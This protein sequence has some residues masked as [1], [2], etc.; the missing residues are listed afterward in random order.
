MWS[1]QSYWRNPLPTGPT[2]Y[3][4]PLSCT[5]VQLDRPPSACRSL[6][7]SLISHRLQCKTAGPS[8][9]LQQVHEKKAYKR[10]ERERERKRERTKIITTL[11]L[12]CTIPS[13]RNSH[14]RTYPNLLYRLSCSTAHHSQLQLSQGKLQKQHDGASLRKGL[15]F[16]RQIILHR[17]DVRLRGRLLNA[18]LFHIAS[19]S[20]E[21][22]CS[23]FNRN[24]YFH[25][26]SSLHAPANGEA[27]QDSAQASEK[28]ARL[29]GDN[30]ASSPNFHCPPPKKTS[31]SLRAVS[32]V[33][34]PIRCPGISARPLGLGKKEKSPMHLGGEE[35]MPDQWMK[36][37]HLEAVPVQRKLRQQLFH[38]F[39]EWQGTEFLVINLGGTG[40]WPSLHQDF[41]VAVLDA[42]RPGPASPLTLRARLKGHPCDEKFFAR[43]NGE[44]IQAEAQRVASGIIHPTSSPFHA[45][46]ATKFRPKDRDKKSKGTST[47]TWGLEKGVHCF[48]NSE[49]K[50]A[51]IRNLENSTCLFCLEWWPNM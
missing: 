47:R 16:L 14:H 48:D 43:E 41:L 34:S 18:A 28:S 12:P 24:F 19:A 4:L 10:R 51:E 49:K 9:E 13:P 32:I 6:K 42:T 5:E 8:I 15:F 3:L 1:W 11:E 30:E 50:L 46:H 45:G 25:C 29:R 23:S 27:Q 31:N 20:C 22:I 39:W 35:G 7:L 44:T 2:C 37:I 33:S 36:H 40:R 21:H 17:S 38:N 26:L